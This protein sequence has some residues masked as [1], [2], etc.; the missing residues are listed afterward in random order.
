M[1][2][3]TPFPGHFRQQD[4]SRA[5]SNVISQQLKEIKELRRNYAKSLALV[6]HLKRKN[7]DMETTQSS[8]E[9]HFDKQG[10][11]SIKKS[12]T[13]STISMPLDVIKD[14]EFHIQDKQLHNTSLLFCGDQA[15]ATITNS[16]VLPIQATLFK[17]HPN[18]ESKGSNTTW[19]ELKCT[20][21]EADSGVRI[22]LGI[23]NLPEPV[24][25]SRVD[26]LIVISYP[27]DPDNSV[28]LSRS[29]VVVK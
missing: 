19:E 15:T 18:V 21:I 24:S 4:N 27:E 2:S 3:P 7:T 23:C 20:L 26:Y 6:S 14:V 8:N 10:N 5:M 11:H 13:E 28:T 17:V 12:R 16:H 1:V 29:I 25:Q 22:G 9:L